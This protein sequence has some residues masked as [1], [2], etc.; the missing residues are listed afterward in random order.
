MVAEA[1]PI[2]MSTANVPQR[3]QAAIS[4]SKPVPQSTAKSP[5]FAVL[6]DD[7]EAD[8]SELDF[9]AFAGLDAKQW[10]VELRYRWRKDGKEIIYWNYRR[11]KI[12]HDTDGNRRI[13]YRKG[14]SR[15]R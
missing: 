7:F 15:E 13:E 2:A 1:A 9:L 11:R 8:D 4:E 10:R 6:E 5:G 14:G 3:T 12:H